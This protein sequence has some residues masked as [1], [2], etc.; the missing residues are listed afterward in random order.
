MY[1]NYEK[2]HPIETNKLDLKIGKTFS[3]GPYTCYIPGGRSYRSG[4]F[5]FLTPVW[6][7]DW[8]DE[9]L[10]WDLTCSFHAHLNPSLLTIIRGPDAKRFLSE[11]FVNNIEKFPIGIIKHGIMCLESGLIARMGFCCAPQRMFTRRTGTLRS[12]TMHSA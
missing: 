3:T 10:S 11:N 5:P 9:T 2:A 4:E 1:E 7:T 6:Y 12:S 8:R